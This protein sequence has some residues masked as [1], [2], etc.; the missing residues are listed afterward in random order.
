MKK[1]EDIAGNPIKEGDYVLYAAL[2]SRSATL[3]YG[4]VIK[5]TMAKSPD[6][7]GESPPKV[8]VVTVDRGWDDKWEIQG[9]GW[10]NKDPEKAKLVTLGFVDRMMV[11]TKAQ[12]PEDARKLLD[13]AYKV[14]S[15]A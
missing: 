15:D 3:K 7:R 6:W 5:L 12:I 4:R 11:V 2:W 10:E 14:K 8:Q 13:A 1:H 9:G